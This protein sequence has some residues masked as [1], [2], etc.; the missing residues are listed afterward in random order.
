MLQKFNMLSVIQLAAQIKLAEVWK[1]QN[2]PKCQIQTTRK[3]VTE[4]GRT[5]SLRPGTQRNLVEECKIGLAKSSFGKDANRIWN[6]TPEK[7]MEA[8]SL[9]L[10]KSLI[11]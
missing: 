8:K 10:A 6:Q 2:D 4:E 7:N 9:F 1:V 5:R 3:I 11:K